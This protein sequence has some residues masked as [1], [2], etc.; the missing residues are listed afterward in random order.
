MHHKS[1]LAVDNTIRQRLETF[2]AN[3]EHQEGFALWD[4]IEKL[5]SILM[6]MKEG[7]SLD[8]QFEFITK[9]KNL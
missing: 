7:K 8:D 4:D 3:C 5:E 1:N 6:L 2:V 9:K